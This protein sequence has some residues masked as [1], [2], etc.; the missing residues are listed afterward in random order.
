MG[1]VFICP[2]STEAGF[3][4]ATI[5]AP[6]LEL[7][8][9]THE[10]IAVA[11]ADG[12]ARVDGRPA[13]VY[14]HTHVGLANGLA[15]LSCAQLEHSP[16]VVLNGLKSTRL[17]AAGGF[18]TT[19]DVRALAR[20]FVKW[21]WQT[22]RADAVAADLTRALRTAATAPRGPAYLALPQDLLEAEPDGRT[23]PPAATGGVAA[24]TRPDPEAVRAAAER[25]SAA[26]RP[27]IVAGAEVTDSAGL[28][29][30]AERLRAPVVAEDRRTIAAA[31]FPRDHPNFAGILAP[32][33][34]ASE[35]AARGASPAGT[36]A[37]D[38]LAPADETIAAGAIPAG[39]AASGGL[40]PDVVLLA[41]ARV[42]IAFEADL[43]PSLPPGALVIQ[44]A[45]DPAEAAKLR[46]PALALVGDA[47]LGVADLLA[48]AAPRTDSSFLA[49]ARAG[50]ED[51]P[52]E[53]QGGVAALMRRLAGALAPGD[54]VVD[55]A[56]TSSAELI[57]HVLARPDLGYLRTATGSL[58]WGMG[59]AVGAGLARPD[60]R[61][62]AVIG[63][64]V[65]QFGIQALWTAAR[66]RVPVTFVVVNNGSYGAV[67]AALQRFGG[68]A[69]EEGRFPGSD[70]GG[71]SIAVIASGFGAPGHRVE[72]LADL[73]DA[74]QAA[75]AHA[76]PA[77]VEVM[78]DAD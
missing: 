20:P 52:A 44:I 25:L 2:G 28:A 77:V 10:S 7:V 62:V 4:D 51:A 75:A 26:E 16:V 17:Q 31:P 72:R 74:I 64:G 55:D 1:R 59:A 49:R 23:E 76:G 54:L 6:D 69:V 66:H 47:D 35:A 14:L 48:A 5:D 43:P 21:D 67:K 11:A 36:A 53:A 29:E 40:T 12:H 37:P 50:Y 39:E 58:G 63:D 24:R 42:P 56:V 33:T 68:R 30:L 34:P 32:A 73:D 46:P 18:T 65:F 9:T 8:L 61:T 45:S 70:L 38:G 13:V 60:R 71:P 27:L 15:H 41:G 22:L 57:P 78:T 3:L 19:P